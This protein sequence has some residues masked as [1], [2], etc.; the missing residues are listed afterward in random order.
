MG[1]ERQFDLLDAEG[2]KPAGEGEVGDLVVLAMNANFQGR[3]GGRCG[4]GEE[5]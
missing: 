1:G 4:H 5:R 3:G 2:I